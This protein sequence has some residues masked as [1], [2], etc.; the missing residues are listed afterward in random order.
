MSIRTIGHALSIIALRTWDHFLRVLSS[1]AINTTISIQ[2]LT[3][4]MLL[5]FGGGGGGGCGGG[6]GGG[7]DGVH[8]IVMCWLSVSN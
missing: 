3:V 8:G 2:S 1:A 4:V 7:G 5:C 6:G